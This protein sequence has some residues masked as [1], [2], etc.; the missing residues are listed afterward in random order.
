MRSMF[1]DYHNSKHIYNNVI[2]FVINNLLILSD[3]CKYNINM[4]TLY[5]LCNHKCEASVISEP[6]TI[7]HVIYGFCTH[8]MIMSWTVII[9]NKLKFLIYIPG[10]YCAYKFS[11]WSKQHVHF[12][13]C[14]YIA[15]V[16]YE[17]NPTVN[18]VA[19]LLSSLTH[20][21]KIAQILDIWT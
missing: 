1:V 13:I 5:Y 14:F 11:G 18:W 8:I 17:E 16:P 20:K 10:L 21:C 9:T 19:A 6:H 3:N 4:I 15:H 7:I 12:W 2:K